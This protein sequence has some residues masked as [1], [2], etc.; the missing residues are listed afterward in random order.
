MLKLIKS[1][2]SVWYLLCDQQ[3]GS[4]ED[5]EVGGGGGNSFAFINNISVA[6]DIRKFSG[7]IVI[8]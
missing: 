5:K 2:T 6:N 1:E 8:C 3:V 7:H 4:K